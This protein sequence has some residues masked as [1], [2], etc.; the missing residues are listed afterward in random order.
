MW[1]S[2]IYFLGLASIATALPAPLESAIIRRQSSG[3]RLAVYVQ[4]FHTPDNQPLSLLPLIQENT[5]I[6]HVIL[7]SFHLNDNPGDITLNDKPPSDPQ[8]DQAWSDVKQL[9]AAGV[10]VMGMLGGSAPGTYQRL[11]GDDTSVSNMFRFFAL[12]ID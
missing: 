4:T 1:S 11:S 2:L 8:F 10:K 7:C 9:Q 3:N 12:L 6:T 5:G